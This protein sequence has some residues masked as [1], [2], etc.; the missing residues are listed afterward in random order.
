VADRLNE[1]VRSPSRAQV[2]LE[3]TD[4]LTLLVVC[5]CNF[6]CGVQ[7]DEEETGQSEDQQSGGDD[8]DVSVCALFAERR[9]DCYRH[10]GSLALQGS[11]GVYDL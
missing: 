3:A 8:A 9:A 11:A 7:N 6:V 4:H 5:T 1:P 10:I 2:D